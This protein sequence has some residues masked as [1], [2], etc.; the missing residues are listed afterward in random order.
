MAKMGPQLPVP[1]LGSC[2]ILDIKSQLWAGSIIRKRCL[3]QGNPQAFLPAHSDCIP[4]VI[5][6]G[7]WT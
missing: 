3:Q 1:H 2:H 7:L 5:W 4:P 6:G